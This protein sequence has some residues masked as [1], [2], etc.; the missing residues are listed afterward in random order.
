M[1]VSVSLFHKSHMVWPGIET[2]I[3]RGVTICP[4]IK[5]KHTT[6]CGHK[7]LYNT[8]NVRIDVTVRGLRVNHCCCGK[9]VRIIY[10]G[11]VSVALVIQHAMRMRHITLPSVACPVLQHFFSRY[12]TKGGARVGAV[13][14]GI[15][16]QS[17]RSRVRFFIDTI[18]PAAL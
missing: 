9:A 8:S 5:T 15:A 12:L 10:S 6:P 2:G 4:Q 17:G 3:Q 1:S 18:L 11:C 13:G 14:W 16:P 7:V